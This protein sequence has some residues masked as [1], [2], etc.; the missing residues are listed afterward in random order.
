M[1][2]ERLLALVDAVVVT[3]A[4]SQEE[5]REGI[6]S[7]GGAENLET[8]G[9]RIQR[10]E[11]DIESHCKDNKRQNH[12]EQTHRSYAA[13]THLRTQL[14]D[15]RH[16]EQNT[17]KS[18]QIFDESIRHQNGHDT[19]NDTTDGTDGEK[20]FYGRSHSVEY[21]SH[22]SHN[23]RQQKE[24]AYNLN[25]ERCHHRGIEQQQKSNTETHQTAKN[26]TTQNF[27]TANLL[28]FSHTEPRTFTFFSKKKDFW[29]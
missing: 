20:R 29:K 8:G 6:H 13:I 12:A 25:N 27:H 9:N 28:H 26:S 2:R 19:Q 22:N 16:E 1:E 15:A 4:D 23:T 7:D 11:D 14:G 3:K 10:S 24:T 21:P 17:Q 5:I 18:H